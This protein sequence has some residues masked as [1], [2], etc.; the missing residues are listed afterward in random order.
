MK[1]REHKKNKEALRDVIVKE[2]P[3]TIDR[4]YLK[5]KT[6]NFTGSGTVSCK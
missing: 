2:Y 3:G 5:F 4:Q 1:S 6:I